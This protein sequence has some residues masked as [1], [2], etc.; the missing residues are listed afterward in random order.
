MSYKVKWDNQRIVELNEYILEKMNKH[1]K[2]KTGVIEID[3]DTSYKQKGKRGK[4]PDSESSSKIKPSSHKERQKYISDSSES[5]QKLR[6]KK[7]KPY[8]EISE[9]LKKIKPPMFNR[10]A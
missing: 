6:K 8:E 2:D 4:Y 9:E 5:D 7:Y 1:E 3:S 10:E